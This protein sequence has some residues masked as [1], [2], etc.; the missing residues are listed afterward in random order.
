[1]T[2]AAANTVS[3]N[4]WL[5]DADVVS[6][7]EALSEKPKTEGEKHLLKRL[8]SVKKLRQIAT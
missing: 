8:Q 7:I 3:G 4:F 2:Y 6:L 1:M 5:S